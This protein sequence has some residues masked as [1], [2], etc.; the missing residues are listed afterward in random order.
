MRSRPSTP[1]STWRRSAAIT[2]R[3]AARRRACSPGRTRCSPPARIA[4]WSEGRPRRTACS[5]LTEVE[6]LGAC[7]NAPMVQINDDNFEDLDYDS[8]AAVLDAL[9]E[10]RDADAEARRSVVATA[11]RRAAR[12]ASRRWSTRTTITG[13]NGHEGRSSSRRGPRHH[14]RPAS[15]SRFVLK[16]TFKL[17]GL[18]ILDRHRPRPLFRG[19][20]RDR[21]GPLDA[22]RQG[23]R[24]SPMSTGSS[25]GDLDAAI[26]RAAIGT[27]PRA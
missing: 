7:A 24:S 8:T 3:S 19:A 27:I 4:A 6:C 2:S 21:E 20:E 26:R 13:G 12:P 18:L 16:V 23:S 9:A 10:G 5:R 11:A 22:R 15:C 14:R 25:R 1:C 17:L